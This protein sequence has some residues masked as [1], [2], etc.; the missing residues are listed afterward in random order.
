MNRIKRTLAAGALAGAFAMTVPAAPVY[1][2][3]AAS[4]RNLILLGAGAAY[5][6]VQ[7]NRKVHEHYAEDAQRQAALEAQNDQ[8][9]AAYEHERR[10]YREEAAANAAL[11]REIAYQHTVIEQQRRQLAAL[12]VHGDFIAQHGETAHVSYGWGSI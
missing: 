1:A 7:H 8:E 4:T 11:E 12:N 9:A 10:A 6:I 3:G 2:D 5:L